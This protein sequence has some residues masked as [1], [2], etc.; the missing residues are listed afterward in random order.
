MHIVIDTHLSQEFPVQMQKL[1]EKF[2]DHQWTI[3]QGESQAYGAAEG[4][5]KLVESATVYVGGP[6][7]EEIYSHAKGLRLHIIP[8]TGVNRFPLQYIRDRGILLVNNH[9][10]ALSVAE[11]ALALTLGVSGRIVEFH[12][13]MLLGNWH[14]NQPPAPVFDLW[15][16]LVG[17]KV[18]V[19]GTGAIGA[20]YGRLLSG[21][22]VDLLGYRRHQDREPQPPFKAMAENLRH[23]LTGQDVIL[24][25]LPATEETQDLLGP[26][27][28]EWARGAILVNVS[29][30]EIIQEEALYESLVQ[31]CLAGAGLDVWYDYPNPYW[32]KGTGSRFDFGSLS[33]VVV[34]PHAA[35]HSTEGK[36]GQ[37][38]HTL[39]QLEEFLH[40]GTV[41]HTVDLNLGY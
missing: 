9:G 20:A 32:A 10:N 31:G 41:S 40:T 21:F 19:L 35:S 25:A 15:K 13:D 17:A 39:E 33:N 7:S 4:S 36:L 2:P 6:L 5:G 27:E 28:L 12:N 14:R 8:Y 29:R 18:S 11:R 16:S 38:L 22:N 1:M 34:S 3:T 37:W 26:K 24:V 23:A 30:A